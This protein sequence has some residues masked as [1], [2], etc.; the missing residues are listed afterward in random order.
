MSN[1]SV[2]LLTRANATQKKED[3]TSIRAIDSSMPCKY[4]VSLSGLGCSLNA[5]IWD[6]NIQTQINVVKINEA[7]Y[8]FCPINKINLVHSSTMNLGNFF[9][10]FIVLGF[11]NNCVDL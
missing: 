3:I 10:R 11:C 5:D 9:S 8:T 7:Y 4:A 6:K 1:N 2:F